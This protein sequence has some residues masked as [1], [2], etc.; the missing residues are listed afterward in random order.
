MFP[1]FLPSNRPYIIAEIGGN[2][3]GS[4]NKA[5]Q[6]VTAAAEAGADSAKFQLYQ[7][8][9]LIHE[10]EPP[11]PLA[12]DNY[13]TQYGRFKE[14]ELSKKE[15]TEVI[16]HCK[17]EGIDFSASVFDREMLD[18]V[19]S[20]TPFIKIASG[21]L[22]NLPLL[23]YSA[24]TEKPIILS[25]GFSTLEEIRSVVTDLSDTELVLLHCMGCYPTPD[26]EANLEMISTLSSEFGVPVGY[27]DHTVGTLAPIMSVAKGARVIEKHFTLNKDQEIGDHRLSATPTEMQKIVTESKR[28]HEMNGSA[29]GSKIYDCEKEIRTNMRRSLATRT[30]INEGEELTTDKITALRPSA[31]ISPLKYDEI[32]GKYVK[33]DIAPKEILTQSDIKP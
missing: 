31:G 27:S 14:L 6:Y 21:D 22:T 18:F 9:N 32:V 12:G 19:K 15:W 2:H 10:D 25:T 3:G 11:L 5:K 16:N 13:D 1:E 24:S 26:E 23:R 33:K 17:S 29:R 7:A 4:V 20:D 30:H 28:A 8:E